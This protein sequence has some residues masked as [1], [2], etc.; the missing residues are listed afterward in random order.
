[1]PVTKKTEDQK[2]E[3]KEVQKEDIWDWKETNEHLLSDG[4]VFGLLW[5][6]KGISIKVLHVNQSLLSV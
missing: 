6:N 1:M 2:E 3:Q 5:T 4:A